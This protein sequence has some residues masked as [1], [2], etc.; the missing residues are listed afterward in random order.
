MRCSTTRCCGKNIARTTG[1]SNST[2]TSYR[3]DPDGWYSRWLHSSGAEGKL[4]VGF[5]NAKADKLIEEARLTLD[6]NKRKELY[7]EVDGIVNDEAAL[8]YCHA[9]PLTSAGVKNLK[10]YQPAIAG[11]FTWSGGGVRSAWFDDTAPDPRSV[12]PRHLPRRG[13]AFGRRI[14]TEAGCRLFRQLA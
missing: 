8:I 13:P 6:K 2:A 12:A 3:F 11:P 9:V 14:T 7:T 10:G 5:K 1:E 4:R